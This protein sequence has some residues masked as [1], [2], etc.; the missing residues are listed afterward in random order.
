MLRPRGYWRHKYLEKQESQRVEDTAVQVR[1]RISS[2]AKELF[3]LSVAQINTDTG[4][5]H[6]AYAQC[7]DYHDDDS[8]R[9]WVVLL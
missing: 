1:S 5:S 7:F 3:T 9:M 4:V 6:Q 8:F 2:L